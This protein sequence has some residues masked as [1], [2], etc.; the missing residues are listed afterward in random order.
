[1]GAVPLAR[2]VRSGLEESV[3]TG[4]LAVCDADGKVIARAGDPSHLV[5]ARSCMK[6]LQA[7]VSLAAMDDLALPDREVAVMCASHNGEPV[8]LGAVRALLERAG[9]G[10]EALQTPPDY[11]LDRDEMAR[12]QH[13]NRVFHNCSGKHSGMLL[14]C[15]RAGWNV[16]TYRRRSN[17]LQRRVRSAVEQGTGV[18]D[19][20]IGVDGC[21]VP[22]HG[23]PL[24]AM[25]TL[26]ARLA[27][28][29]RLGALA[30]AAGR[31]TA[32][33]LAEPYL[34]GGR[35]RLDTEVIRITGEVVV[36]EGAEAL[37]CASI[38]PQGVGIALKVADGGYRAYAPALIEV[39]RQVDA[40]SGPQ[41]RELATF[42]RPSVIGGGE[43]VGEV[44]P[45]V[46][47]RR[48]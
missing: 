23:M 31:A 14:A 2:V 37:I 39:L 40:V 19:L 18:E 32:A 5:F 22:V 24:Q 27:R 8:H 17:P 20:V 33:M 30:P 25:A 48:R 16:E 1:M 34:V 11:P 9:L 7:S 36:K 10:P 6:P 44:E 45:L 38:Q 35:H 42:A 21:G 15:V 46:T 4:H 26:F 13:P 43:R 47:L 3:H 12:A 28:P 41:L 29:E